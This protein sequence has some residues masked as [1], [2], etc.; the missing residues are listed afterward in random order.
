VDKRYLEWH[1]AQY[2]VRVKVSRLARPILGKGK[3]VRSL[4]IDSLA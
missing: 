3:L 1:G 2:R 4:H